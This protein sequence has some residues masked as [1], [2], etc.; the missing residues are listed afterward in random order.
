LLVHLQIVD[1][2][3]APIPFKLQPQQVPMEMEQQ[4]IPEGAVRT[5]QDEAVVLP[6]NW[7]SLSVRELYKLKISPQLIQT[8]ANRAQQDGAVQLGQAMP[9]MGQ[10]DQPEMAL[11]PRR[12][13]RRRRTGEDDQQYMQDYFRSTVIM[14]MEGQPIDQKSLIIERPIKRPMPFDSPPKSHQP[15]PAMAMPAL[16]DILK[17]FMPPCLGTVNAVDIYKAFCFSLEN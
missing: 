11:L 14:P 7:Q 15:Q 2:Q 10:A 8:L 4:N 9:A 6:A 17:K 5:V 16:S 13:R 12:S 3:T 1:Y